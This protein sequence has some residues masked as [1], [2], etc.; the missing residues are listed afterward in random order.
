MGRD[1]HG[2][3]EALRHHAGD[4]PVH[5][6][7]ALEEHLPPHGA[8]AFDLGQVVVHD[9][10]DQPGGDVLARVAFLHRGPDV[11]V[12]EGRTGRLELDGVLGPQ[13]YLTDLLQRQAQ[14]ALGALLQERARPGRSAA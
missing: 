10:V 5:G 1:H 4:G 11:R 14:V 3:A 12:D 7:A 13:G 9:G 8:G 2:L 6:H